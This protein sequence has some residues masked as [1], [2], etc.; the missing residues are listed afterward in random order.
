MIIKGNKKKKSS[1]FIPILIFFILAALI[2]FYAQY[3]GTKKSTASTKIIR[4]DAEFVEGKNFAVNGDLFSGGIHQSDAVAYKGAHSM[5]LSGKNNRG[6]EYVISLPEAGTTYKASV[7]RYAKKDEK[8]GVLIAAS[9]DKSI[10]YEKVSKHVAQTP[11][12][13]FQLELYFT[14]PT[15]TIVDEVRIYVM[16]EGQQPIYFD[17]LEIEKISS[18]FS[19]EYNKGLFNQSLHILLENQSL[20]RLKKQREQAII[21]G[22]FIRDEKSEVAAAIVEDQ[23]NEKI[24]LRYKGDWLDH[25]LSNQPSYRIE[26]K[27]EYAWNGLQSF[28]IQHPKTRGYMREWIY[29]DLL[30][31]VDVLSPRYD[32]IQVKVNQGPSKVYAIEEHF[33]K[34]LV[35]SKK[36]REGPILKLSEDQMWEGMVR[37][38]QQQKGLAP[39]SNK[40][41]A[42]WNSD[43][44]PFKEGRT[45]KD[46]VLSRQFSVAQNLL[47]RYKLGE[48]SV[49]E[50]FDI[51]KL[52]R[53]MA[54]SE[55][56]MANHSLTWHNQ[57]FYYNPV[58][59]LLEPVGFDCSLF[60]TDIKAFERPLFIQDVLTKRSDTDEPIIKIFRDGDFLS[61]F[62]KY[63]NDY[64][65]QTF[66]QTYLSN[67]RLDINKR[68]QLIQV[69]EKNYAYNKNE[70][71][72]RAKKIQIVLEP[73]SNAVK[74]FSESTDAD[75]VSLKFINTH[76]LP[77]EVEIKSGHRTLRQIVLPQQDRR[78]PHY[79]DIKIH[80][81]GSA[82]RYRLP[83]SEQWHNCRISP[84]TTPGFQTPRVELFRGASVSDT[85]LFVRENRKIYVKSGFHNIDR[86]I[87]IPDGYTL[88]IHPG[89]TLAFEEDGLI[90]S[91]S[92]IVAK[93]SAGF[94]IT[95]RGNGQNGSVTILQ[96][97]SPSYLSHVIFDNQNTLKYKGWT[98]TGAVTFYES[99]VHV[100][101]CKFINNT[102]EDALNI[103]RS[104]FDIEQ[105]EFINIF[106]DAFDAD[107]CEGRLS[108]SSFR[109]T[110]NDAIDFSTSVVHVEN[111]QMTQIG[112]KGISAGEQATV[113]AREIIIDEANIAFA[114]KDRSILIL[115]EVDLS[116]CKKGFAAYQKK[117]EFGPATIKVFGYT[118]TDIE[119]L[120]LIEDGSTLVK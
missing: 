44:L 59:S 40:N 58:I 82:V 106:S 63:L 39:A 74:V 120:F 108:R 9:S 15:D 98:L 17:Q 7:W 88:Y 28:S 70:L 8:K 51:D 48:G 105:A 52:A 10:L 38:K 24:S 23:K 102:C 13:W 61:L 33:T 57:R 104:S 18:P 49:G 1:S 77:L 2:F 113:E 78:V 117:P 41:E 97:P 50:T 31:Q 69:Q 75:S 34:Y 43:L 12:W 45:A 68:E 81:A 94:P 87:I 47:Y 95:F 25:I 35:E 14:I 62:F 53:F 96:A 6:M 101:H 65:Q 42:Y 79:H 118:E 67:R 115:R 93:G 11:D 89:T 119:N 32:F 16:N 111:C 36:R 22:V 56:C 19:A 20:D 107:F 26:C 91:A 116:N 86:P 76:R 83:G 66:I 90:L 54:I 99:E 55:L 72:D 100:D 3:T 37:Y 5:E 29:H 64:S 112:D 110:G 46:S 71:V 73:K 114:S 85:A 30:T 103:V 60:G 21:D 109:N 4:C 27:K 84:W 92:P 80:R